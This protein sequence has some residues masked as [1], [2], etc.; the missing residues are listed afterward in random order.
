[1]TSQVIACGVLSV[2]LASAAEAQVL[3]L[4]PPSQ[5]EN[6][7]Q[8]PEAVRRSIEGFERSLSGA[9]DAAAPTEQ[10]AD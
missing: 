2:A 9:V 10:A 4:D 7:L 5:A 8:V 1:M 6:V 3:V